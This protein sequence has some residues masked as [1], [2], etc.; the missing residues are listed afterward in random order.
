MALHGHPAVASSGIQLLQ[1]AREVKAT[2]GGL[3]SVSSIMQLLLALLFQV[4]GCMRSCLSGVV[5]CVQ[6]MIVVS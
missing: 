4:A 6:T 2:L 1:S 5:D 3:D